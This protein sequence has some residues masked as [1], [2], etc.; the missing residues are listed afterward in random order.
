MFEPLRPRHKIV[1]TALRR[2]EAGFLKDNACY[3]GGGTRI[4]LELGEYR[5]SAD[6]DFLCASREG[7]RALRSAVNDASLGAIARPGLK[8]AREVIADRYGIRTWL[9]VDGEKLKFEIVL[10]AR[11]ALRGAAE[12]GSPV[13]VLDR[14]SC[15]AEKFLAN[16]DRWNDESVLGRDAIDLA[17]MAANWG[18]EPLRQGCAVATE[19]YGGIVARAVKRAATRLIEQPAWRRRCVTTLTISDTKTLLAG[20]RLVAG[21]RW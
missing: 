12:K 21:T 19:A 1:L 17:F 15:C 18:V 13:A 16:A 9:D 5:E 7:Y 6:V 20:L 8:L 3:F 4:V 2:L 10:E 11:I 14:V